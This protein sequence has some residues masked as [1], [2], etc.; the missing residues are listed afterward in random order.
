LAATFRPYI[1]VTAAAPFF[2]EPAMTAR[3]MRLWAP[4]GDLG[5]PQ[6][7]DLGHVPGE[8]HP[9]EPACEALPTRHHQL[10]SGNRPGPEM[11]RR[12]AD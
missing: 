2:G 9:C 5:K 6:R 7:H 11:M 8:T 3:A 1:R 10:L 12:A 4:A